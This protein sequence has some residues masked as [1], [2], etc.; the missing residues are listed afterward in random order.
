MAEWRKLTVDLGYPINHSETGEKISS[1]VFHEPN[2]EELELMEEGSKDRGGIGTAIV[3]ME[4]LLDNR[5][6]I[7]IIRKLHRED[8]EKVS[9][10]LGPFVRGSSPS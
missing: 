3:M 5:D 10:K 6:M 8:F 2:A 1:L 9:G 4:T 7:P